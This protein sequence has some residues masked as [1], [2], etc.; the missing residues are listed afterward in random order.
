M[1]VIGSNSAS[2][3]YNLTRSLRFRRSASGYLSRTAGAGSQQIMT[4]SFWFKRG[5]LGVAQ[6]IFGSYSSGS[7]YSNLYL[8]STNQIGFADAASATNLLSTQVFRDPSAWYHIVVAIDTTQATAANR[9]KFYVNNVQITA[10]ASSTYPAQNTNL[11]L[12]SAVNHT[13][14]NNAA[15]AATNYTDGYLAETNFVNAQQLTPSSFGSTNALTGVWQPAA[16]TGTYGTNGFY[17]PFTDN[18]ALTTSSNVGLGKDFSG[19][20]NYWVT[21]NISVTAGV[22]YDSMT[23]VPTLTSAPAANFAVL[24]PLDCDDLTT[25]S[26]TNGNLSWAGV[27][28][29][30]NGH[31][32]RSTF[33]VPPSGK[34]YVEARNVTFSGSGN[35]LPIGFTYSTQA[36][37][38]ASVFASTID[39]FIGVDASVF[40]NAVT[41]RTNGVSASLVAYTTLF[42]SCASGDVINFAIDLN[43]G[44]FWIGKNGT[45]YNSG[46][47][48]AGTNATSTFTVGSGNWTFLAEYVSAGDNGNRS[49]AVLNFGQQPFTLTPP[50]GFLAMNTYNLPT[51]TI[52]KGNTVMDVLTWS[53]TGGIASATRSLT[54]LNF[55]PDFVWEKDRA[56]T[57][58]HH[59]FDSV[60]GAGLSRTLASNSTAAEG[61]FND[62]LYG[63]LSSFDSN[64]VTTTN[65]SSTWDNWNKSGDTYVA[66]AWQAGQGSTSSNTNGSITSTVS[67]NASAGFSVV[68][69][70]GSGAT[71]TVGHGLGVAPSFM[72][73]KS[74]SGAGAW[75]IALTYSGFTYSSDYFQFDTGAKRTDGASTVWVT[76]PTSSVFSVGSSFGNGVTFVNYCW[77]P[78][79]GFSAFGS[80]TGNGSTDGPFVYLGFRPRWV[81]FKDT[82]SA[83]QWRIWDTAR[84]PYNITTNAL[85]ANS[86]GTEQSADN[87]LD[88]VSNG[89]KIRSTNAGVNTNAG[90]YIYMAFAENPFK[91]ALAR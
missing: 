15:P 52:V 71:A 56:S 18:S 36:I 41:F 14:F 67:V 26:V 12:N 7:A 40:S 66:W 87:Y 4:L 91:N 88:I 9:V 45:W 24:N 1:L 74:R 90:N 46:D 34:W 83:S 54:G 75:V 44:K 16:Y 43:A 11:N 22:T 33:R 51:S 70:S 84:D 25:G 3:G 80:Y 47:P 86:S 65:G 6:Y 29:G 50:S 21:N 32:I 28:A 73:S 59:L 30:K 5:V 63:Y 82:V 85:Y 62:T 17:L 35:S 58:D 55:K 2:T 39:S 38:S 8:E 60:R 61:G 77:T 57:Q 78:I 81:M 13:L 76:A 31:P 20:A 64:G 53:G 48:A 72:I 89:F 69:F 79:A 19:N 27:Y 10:F 23:D 37:T 49:S 42:G 68:T